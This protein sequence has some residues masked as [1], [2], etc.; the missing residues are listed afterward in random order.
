MDY[1]ILP[2]RTDPISSL[3]CIANIYNAIGMSGAPVSGP[4]VFTKSHK[5]ADAPKGRFSI[6]KCAWYVECGFSRIRCGGS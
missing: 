1:G 4:Y 5:D 2:V 3:I 6:T